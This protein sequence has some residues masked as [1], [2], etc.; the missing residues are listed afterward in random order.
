[1]LSTASLSREVAE[2]VE[3]CL[4]GCF[5]CIFFATDDSDADELDLEDKLDSVNYIYMK[6]SF[7]V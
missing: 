7:Q 5:T 4:A 3:S 6:K 2:V 1:M